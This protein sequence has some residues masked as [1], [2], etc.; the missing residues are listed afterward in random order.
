MSARGVCSCCRTEPPHLEC[1]TYVPI[2]LI[3]KGGSGEEGGVPGGLWGVLARL[4]QVQKYQT[5]RAEQDCQFITCV[6]AGVNTTNMSRIFPITC[7]CVL[8]C[9]QCQPSDLFTTLINLRDALSAGWMHCPVTMTTG[10][11]PRWG[12]SSESESWNDQPT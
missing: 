5:Q 7:W 9:L 10:G 8:T 3:E 2:H 11:L 6:R 12:A 4:T 1:V